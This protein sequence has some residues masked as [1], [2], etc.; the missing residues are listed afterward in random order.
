MVQDFLQDGRPSDTH[1][2]LS[3]HWRDENAHRLDID[4][5][6]THTLPVLFFPPTFLEPF[7]FRL[8]P[9]PKV[10]QRRTSEKQRSR[11]FLL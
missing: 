2:K 11:I 1:T 10:F 5:V 3:N 8:G 9:P 7:Q 6:T 4:R